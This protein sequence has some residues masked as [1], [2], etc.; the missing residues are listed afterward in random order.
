MTPGDTAQNRTF[1]AGA[2]VIDFAQPQAR[3][4]RSLLEPQ[5]ELDADFVAKQIAKYERNNRRGD[6]ATREFYEFYDVTAWAL[7]YTLGLHA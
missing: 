3:L 4:A 6:N 7:P 2:L 5:P 1:G